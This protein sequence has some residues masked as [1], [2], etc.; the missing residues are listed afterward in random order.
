MRKLVGVAT[1][2]AL[3]ASMLTGCKRGDEWLP[4]SP[5]ISPTILPIPTS[6]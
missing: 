4:P 3:L 5:D 2:F 6:D 1:A